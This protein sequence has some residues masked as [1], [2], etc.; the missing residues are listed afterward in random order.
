MTTSDATLPPFA[1]IDGIANF[2]D[3]GG[4]TTPTGQTITKGLAFRCADPSKVTSEGLDKMSKDLGKVKLTLLTTSGSKVLYPT[5]I[6]PPGIKV[7]FDLRSLPE[8][9]RNGPEYA[10]ISS[11]PG[12]ALDTLFA[13]HDITRRWV[14]VFAADDYGPEQIALRYKAYTRSGTS[15]FVQA[16]RDILSNAGSAFGAI[17]RHLSQPGVKPSACVFHCT[18]GKDRTGLLAALLLSLAGVTD[19][20]IADEYALTDIGLAPLRELFVERLLKNPV[21]AGDEV[22]VRNMVSSKCENMLASLKMIEDEFEGCEGYMRK[23]CGLGDEE[24]EVLRNRLRV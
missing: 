6:S 21:L 14:P 16:Y 15:G 24:I 17:L 3:I 12:S 11:D 7:I 4:Y 22:G 1:V 9:N 2:R 23:W 8:I 18:A 19:N 10:G 13:D 5:N 20:V